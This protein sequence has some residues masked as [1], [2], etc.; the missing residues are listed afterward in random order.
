MDNLN[1]KRSLRTTISPRS[2]W[3][4]NYYHLLIVYMTMILIFSRSIFSKRARRK[5]TE[6]SYRAMLVDRSREAEVALLLAKLTARW[7]PAAT[8]VELALQLG[9]LTISGNRNR[10]VSLRKFQERVCPG[11]FYSCNETEQI[12]FAK[13]LWTILEDHAVAPKYEDD[14]IYRIITKL[15]FTS[16][17]SDS[18]KVLQL[19]RVIYTPTHFPG[20]IENLSRSFW[21]RART[22]R[23]E[24]SVDFYPR[25]ARG[26]VPSFGAT[27]LF[28]GWDEIESR[29]YVLTVNA[30]CTI[31][32][33][34]ELKIRLRLKIAIEVIR[35]Y[36]DMAG[37]NKQLYYM[38]PPLHPSLINNLDIGKTR[39]EVIRPLEARLAKIDYVI[40]KKKEAE[41][42]MIALIVEKKTG[43][44]DLYWRSCE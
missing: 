18:C 6:V 17:V 42:A 2:S 40:R 33:L 15:F 39:S 34:R 7:V 44:R 38:F 3:T 21:T 14:F 1:R 24:M 10:L 28:Q 20:L 29:F 30:N 36:D 37:C 25:W 22:Y 31:Q 43:V 26:P 16:P 35:A 19:A 4:F 41:S 32:A 9:G 11:F 13:L 27:L 12:E 23:Q 8:K 5:R